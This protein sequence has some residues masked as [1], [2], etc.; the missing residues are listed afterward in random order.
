MDP[1]QKSKAS[2]ALAAEGAELH[3][4]HLGDSSND[5]WYSVF[6]GGTWIANV[7]VHNQRS[8]AAPALAAHGSRERWHR[9]PEGCS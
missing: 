4:V 9:A 7:T 1:N 3:M 8:K 2:P 6:D 5:I